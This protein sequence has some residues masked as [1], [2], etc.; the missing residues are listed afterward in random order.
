MVEI[1]LN[2]KHWT[3]DSGIYFTGYFI[4]NNRFIQS[5][6][7]LQYI[8]DFRNLFELKELVNKLNGHFAIIINANDCTYLISDKIRSIPL[9]FRYT[10]ERIIISDEAINCN[11]N[12]PCREFDNDSVQTFLYCGY[13][14]NNK[15]LYKNIYVTEPGNVIQLRNDFWDSYP[16]YIYPSS[17]TK[18]D[19][20]NLNKL[21]NEL[22]KIIEKIFSRLFKNLENKPIAISLSG[23]FDSRLIALM[24][25]KYHPKNL[26]F[27]SYGIKKHMEIKIAEEVAL[28]LGVKW[29]FIEYNEKIVSNFTKDTVFLKYY[30][31]AANY[32]SMF[33]LQ[34]YFAIKQ[35]KEKQLVPD[36]CVFIPGHS[37]DALAGSHLSSK[38][39]RY[40]SK[41]K[42]IQEIYN[43]HFNQLFA[44]ESVKKELKKRIE[45]SIPPSILNSWQAFDYW[46]LHQRQPKFIIN[47]CRVYSYFGYQY[48]LPL[49]NDEIHDFFL[50]LPFEL[51][52][53]KK[54]Y[55][56]VL[57]DIFETKNL[58]FKREIEPSI[59]RKKIQEYKSYIKKIFPSFLNNLFIEKESPF[60]YN[61][62]TQILR[63]QTKPEFVKKTRLKNFFNAYIIQWYV[64]SISSSRN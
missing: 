42:I 44:N 35:I 43:F 53:H 6:E 15:T 1:I 48:F 64:Q 24:A 7:A 20:G 19:V 29:L 57:K 50:H 8:T 28:N 56:T 49:W 26:Y 23:G 59:F 18:Y 31:Y 58:N 41:E 21:S 34:D 47:S 36:D 14:L 62:I 30:P 12:N 25:A 46:Y 10:K 5:N 52:V 22:N 3:T 17:V 63:K 4:E 51:R 39:I 33:F 37:G 45:K 54:L 27:F 9:F 13:T 38:L 55:N 16:Y 32:S 60:F 11:I 61:H 40:K 2:N